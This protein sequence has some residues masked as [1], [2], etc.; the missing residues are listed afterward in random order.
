[1]LDNP[2][3]T[4]I[5]AAAITHLR[6]AV[7]PAVIDRTAFDLRVILSALDLVA[8]EMAVGPGAATS[9]AASLSH[10][11]GGC[12]GG[13]EELNRRLEANISAGLIAADDQAL[14]AHLYAVTAA[15]LAVDQPGYASYQR[16]LKSEQNA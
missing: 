14:I 7:L 1:M 15:K 5:L 2:S 4:T 13:L 12:E 10:L 8:R 11:L 9:E 3:A 6:A 16:H